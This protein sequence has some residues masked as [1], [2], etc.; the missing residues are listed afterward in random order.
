M[1]GFCL[2]KLTVNK[3]HKPSWNKLSWNSYVFTYLLLKCN[4]NI[5]WNDNHF[6][7]WDWGKGKVWKNCMSSEK[8]KKNANEIQNRSSTMG[9]L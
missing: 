6:L 5:L 1:V 4:S 9:I 3:G 7:K 2:A 8:L